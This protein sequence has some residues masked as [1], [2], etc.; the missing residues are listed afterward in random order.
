M[1]QFRG[2]IEKHVGF[3]L[4]CIVFFAGFLR[5]Y[6]VNTV[7]VS[8]Y[9][10]EVASAYNAY[11]I[12]LTG[13]DEFGTTLPLLFK[14]FDDYKASGNIYLMAIPVTLFGLNE[15]TARATSVILGT[16]SVLVTFFLVRDL[17]AFFKKDLKWSI[18]PEILSLLTVFLL[19]ISPWHIQFS[20]T[21]FE[22]NVALFFIVLGTWL[23]VK[24][25]KIPIY[26]LFSMISFAVS[27]YMYR[28][29]YVFLPFFFLTISVVFFKE[30]L[31]M[32]K[33]IVIG[34]IVT[35]LIVV[36]P[37][38]PWMFSDGG[39][40]RAR[41]VSIVTNSND[42]V[43]DSAEKALDTGNTLWSKIVFNRRV[44]YASETF[45]NYFV[46]FSPLF[47]FIDG[48]PNL[49]HTPIGMGVMYI[50]ELPFVLIGLFVIITRLPRRLG[51]FILFW[52]LIA[53]LPA[54]VSVPNPHALRSLNILPMPQLVVAM[55]MYWIYQVM[56]KKWRVF[57]V[58]FLIGVIS[59]FFGR[60]IYLYY[61]ITAAKSSQDWADGYKQL[62]TYVSENEDSYDK[63]V[64][65]GHYW[66]PYIYF[67]FYNQYD[68]RLYQESGSKAGFGKYVF[69]GTAWDKEQRST[70]LHDVNLREFANANHILVALSPS[71]Y[72]SQRDSVIKLEEIYDHNGNL[73]FIV[74]EMP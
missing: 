71:E 67:L 42:E 14:S 3:L 58:I 49:R 25:L 24:A 68:P 16:L 59:F 23:C 70:E 51:I 19:A 66:Q 47:L 60:Y 52:I 56:Q 57:Y 2:F 38:L 29:V 65:S 53:P 74:G 27:V 61:G 40:S 34:G 28:S 41:Q 55:G 8:L 21:G 44:V 4:L 73:V 63:V 69:G 39:M 64:I 48:D 5:V 13:R 31:H 26:F 46:H 37:F 32:S 12:G 54:S 7:P 45:Q 36:L 9:W 18:K 43:F 72:E 62:V 1:I 15:F 30:F 17:F 10:D 6:S 22:A 33:K 11:S 20:R 35:F 50:W